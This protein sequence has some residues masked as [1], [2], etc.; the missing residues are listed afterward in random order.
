MRVGEQCDNNVLRLRP[1]L[2]ILDRECL[3]HGKLTLHE[4][5]ACG[6]ARGYWVV[7]GVTLPGVDFVIGLSLQELVKGIRS[8]D[9]Q[10]VVETHIGRSRRSDLIEGCLKLPLLE[11][12]QITRGFEELR[13]R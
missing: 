6:C 9:L 1:G 3:R 8:V 5:L 11:H 2:E 7:D 4:R 12:S 13:R 10:H